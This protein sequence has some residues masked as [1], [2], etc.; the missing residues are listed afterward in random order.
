MKIPK[1]ENEADEANPA[2]EHRGDL[3]AAFP[4]A[5]EETQA[6]QRTLK[7]RAE[8]R[9]SWSSIRLDRLT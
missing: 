8:Q 6:R 4:Q 2:H 3:A 9:E 5:A 7:G 1:S